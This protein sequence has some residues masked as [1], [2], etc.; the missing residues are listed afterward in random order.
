M[1]ISNAF[2]SN[3]FTLDKLMNLVYVKQKPWYFTNSALKNESGMPVS[4]LLLLSWNFTF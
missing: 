2:T 3:A 1:E 4:K